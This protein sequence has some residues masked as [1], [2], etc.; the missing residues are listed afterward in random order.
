MMSRTASLAAILCV[1][2]AVAGAQNLRN[3]LVD[4]GP[5]AEFPPDS[6]T[7][8]QYVDSRG[9]VYVRAGAIG[10]PSWVPRVTSSR[11]VLCGFRPTQI[12]REAPPVIADPVPVAPRTLD[13]P[14]PRR[15]ADAPAAA[16]AQAAPRVIA[17]PTPRRKAPAAPT[18]APYNAA[19]VPVSPPTTAARLEPGERIAIRRA[20]GITTPPGYRSAWDDD[21]LNPNRGK[22]TLRGALQT[23]LVWTQT[24]PRRLKTAEGRDVT[25]TYHYLVYPYTD[26][27]K[28]LSDL[29]G[30]KFITVKTQAG[31]QIVS[32]AALRQTADGR[33]VLSTKSAPAPTAAAPRQAQAATGARYVQVATFGNDANANRTA[34]Q[35]QA[36]GLPVRLSAVTRNGT[37]YTTVLAGPFRDAG[38]VTR[39]LRAARAQGFGDAFAR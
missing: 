14:P 28:Q 37:R 3:D 6:Y 22:Q 12:A 2:G 39:G 35:L 15:I 8:R 32:R 20:T 19:P 11:K 30:G 38:G 4:I 29:R 36:A 23:A 31:L 9:C 1:I 13:A 26:Y 25:H 7:A 5:P 17:T 21:R 10:E 27:D 18:P 34:R 33:T 24:V 16:P